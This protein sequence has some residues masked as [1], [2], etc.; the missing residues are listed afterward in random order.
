M[1][2]RDPTHFVE[3]WHLD[4]F[5][6]EAFSACFTVE[7]VHRTLGQQL[8]LGVP[9]RLILAHL[10]YQDREA[11]LCCAWEHANIQHNGARVSFYPDFSAEIQR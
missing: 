6:K 2:G 4:V 9:P 8:L 3:S 10:H 7:R 1:E 5:G 11:V